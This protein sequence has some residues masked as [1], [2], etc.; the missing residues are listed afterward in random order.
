MSMLAWGVPI[1]ELE[2]GSDFSEISN[3][4]HLDGNKHDVCI[5]RGK[6]AKPIVVAHARILF[7]IY[8]SMCIHI[9]VYIYM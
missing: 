7:Y 5:S 4:V 8:I 1:S 3:R 6:N 9:Y 2:I